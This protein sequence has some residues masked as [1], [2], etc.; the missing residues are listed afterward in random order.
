ML[1]LHPMFTLILTVCMLL[2]YVK[3]NRLNCN[4]LQLVSILK[5]QQYD[6][7]QKSPVA[8]VIFLPCGEKM[9]IKGI[10][11]IVHFTQKKDNLGVSSCPCISLN[12]SGI[13][14]SIF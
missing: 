14:E 10:D 12:H 5:I 7:F 3:E 8:E 13:S 9:E 6:I 11:P 4:G 1:C 2:L